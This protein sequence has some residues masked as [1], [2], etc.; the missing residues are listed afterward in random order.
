MRSHDGI[1]KSKSKEISRP[2]NVSPN[3]TKQKQPMSTATAIWHIAKFFIFAGL[4]IV[5]GQKQP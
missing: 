3:V 5:A 2:L 4:A 1:L